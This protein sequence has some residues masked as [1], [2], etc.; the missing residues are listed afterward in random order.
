MFGFAMLNRRAG[1]ALDCAALV[2]AITLATSSAFAALTF[3]PLTGRVVD[4]A[5]ILSPAAR[6]RIE[7]KERELEDKSGI[8]LV[9]ATVSSLHGADIETFGYQLGR[10]WKLGEA[11]KNNGVLF[12]VAPNER[13]V[14][15]DVGYGLEGTLT[16][17]LSKIIISTTVAPQ[18]KKGDFD[19]GVE[20]GVD[21][22][23]DVLTT[24]SGEWQ[25][26]AKLRTEGQEDFSDQIL[27]FVIFALVLFS[28]YSMIRSA[29]GGGRYRRGG[30]GPIVFLPPG[31]DSWGGDHSWGGGGTSS[32]GEY[33]G[34][35]DSGGFSGGGGSFGGGGA[36]GD[37]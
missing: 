14:R 6:A 37:W 16:D 2:V 32:G 24:D 10:F 17:A 5:G 13:K 30:G 20:R 36:S 18:F 9:V 11:K 34:G 35:G 25:K 33:F 15:I 23:V 22:I 31:K 8:Q 7:S 4:N 27:F 26:R 3:P 28:I 21:A 19:A 29:R 1:L 12:L